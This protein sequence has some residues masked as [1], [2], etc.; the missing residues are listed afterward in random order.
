MLHST[1]N[2][3]RHRAVLADCAMVRMLMPALSVAR[4]KILGRWAGTCT[5]C[6]NTILNSPRTL[7]VLRR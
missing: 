5:N 1:S 4:E 7:G 6:I 2:T 3:A